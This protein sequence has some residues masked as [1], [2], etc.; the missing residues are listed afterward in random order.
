[1][2]DLY[3]ALS[4]LACWM[5]LAFCPLTTTA[6]SQTGTIEGK[7]FSAGDVALEGVSIRIDGK[8]TGTRTDEKG[9]F[10]L[11][12]IPAGDHALIFSRVG[13]ATLRRAVP[14][15]AGHT[16]SLE[17]RLEEKTE[18][19]QEVE[20]NGTRGTDRVTY[21]REVE[22]VGVYA[23][24]KTEIINPDRT[25][26]NLA[27]N[28]TRQVF[29]RV[30]GISIWEN[31][32]SG[33]QVGVAARGLSPNRSWEFNVRQ[34][35]YDVSADPL[36]Y[37][38]AYYNPPMEAVQQ[39]QV[40]RGAASLQYGPQFGGLLN[41]VL[42]SGDSTRKVAVETQHTVGS[43]GLYNTYNGV[44]GQVG[45][46]NYY[47]AFNY[48]RADGW[49]ENSRYDY[50]WGYGSLQYAF[51]SR[52]KIG[53]QLSRTYFENQ[54][55]GGLTD[56][57][58]AQ[59]SRQANRSRNWF[60]TPWTMPA[61]N[62]HYQISPSTKL[63]VK[64]FGLMGQ[65]NSVG[66]VAAANVADTINPNTG[67]FNNRQLDR[68]Y[69]R[70]FGGEARLLT[71]YTLLG[72]QHTLATGVRYF[73]G[74]TKRQ[75]LGRGTTGGDFDLS[76]LDPQYRREYEFGSRNV[77]FFAENVFRPFRRL[78]I[79]P[80]LRFEHLYT[81]SAGR[82]NLAADGTPVLIAPQAQTRN[83][84]L[85]GLG[86]EYTTTAST[87][88]YA[89]F[90]QAYRPVQFADLVPPATTDEIDPNLKDAKGYN[91]DFGFRGTIG[92]FARFDLGGFYLHYDGRI[93]TLTQTREDGTRYQYRTNI[94]TSVSKGT[95]LYAEVDPVRAL[96]PASRV[97]SLTLFASMAYVDARYTAG[98][99]V[100][101]T[102][103]AELKGKRVENAPSHINRF[104]I[105][106]VLKGFS[107]TFQLSYVGATFSDANNTASSPNGNNGVIPEYRVMD[108][109]FTYRFPKIFNLKGGVNNL[110]DTQYFTRRAG[111]YPGPGLIP[112]DGRTFYL[113][114]GARF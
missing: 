83:F 80:G 45:K 76:L 69:Y 36:G 22:G 2:K 106:Y 57:Q 17:L 39:L 13:Y 25:D 61:F 90:S 55:P 70:N 49:R 64:A 21:L 86:L 26:A 41:Y 56:A 89:N 40:V 9:Y 73:D 34:N 33:I 12:D 85:L 78:S 11:S 98:S 101:G 88:V 15:Q 47:G 96:L 67:D 92:D 112:G 81:T 5:C 87:S 38:E 82:M 105:T 29:A 104:G 102:T 94:G 66:F 110:A 62:L 50:F 59:D 108:W 18:T 99:F 48:R 7:I 10:N 31:D 42:K 27:L 68:D 71:G 111:G 107:T 79:T 6:Q 8:N 84:V 91:A 93:G 58:F 54:Q 113:T 37:P 75:Q 65:R 1:M 97:G 43:Y 109:S 30:P 60:S 20:V 4:H 52:L 74:N 100:S 23:G 16:T 32:G 28:N 63:D 14:V 24:K 46:L 44:G 35:G 103:N 95:E 72:S 77:A 114:A 3:A 53:F 19:L 51:S